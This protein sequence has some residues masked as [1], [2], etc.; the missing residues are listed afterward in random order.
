MQEQQ[1]GMSLFDYKPRKRE[2]NDSDIGLLAQKYDA[3]NPRVYV[4]FKQYAKQ[5]KATGREHFGAKAIF[6]R[7]RWEMALSTFSDEWKL[8]NNYT[9][10]YSR[11][12]MAEL[13]EFNGFFRTRG[14]E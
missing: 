14:I 13:P 11:K 3:E 7:I 2:Y 5:M 4:L 8:N 10:Y 12:L 9:A 6:E 1:E